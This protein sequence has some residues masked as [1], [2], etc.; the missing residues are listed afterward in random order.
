MNSG[1]SSGSSSCYNSAASSLEDSAESKVKPANQTGAAGKA[2]KAPQ[3]NFVEAIEQ[4]TMK[5]EQEQMIIDGHEIMSV[6]KVQF[7]L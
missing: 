5:R 1:Q 4:I 7:I 2:T 3:L 6:I